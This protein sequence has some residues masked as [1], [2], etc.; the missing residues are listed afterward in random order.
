MKCLNESLLANML[1]YIKTYQIR[2]GK[3]PSYRNI[4]KQF[5]LSS[6]SMVNRYVE[7]LYSRGSL[8]K[9]ICGN[10]DISNNLNAGPTITAPMVGT[11]TCGQP[12][13][14]QENIE[15]NFLLPT[16]IFGH[17]ECFILHAKG[18]SMIDKG[19]R[20]GDLL[21]V[22]K[23]ETAENGQIVVALLDDEATVKTFY[24]KNDHVVL[25]PENEK[26][27]DIITNNVKILGIVEQ[28]I[29]KF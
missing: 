18:D 26:Y 15:G 20:N 7:A 10:I 13:Y 16:A 9:S 23:T 1:E 21:V 2:E 6:L 28:Y 25:H 4:Q 22:K 14:A 8:K 12:I 17:G 27:D 29:H 19:I 24:R 3:S 11:V 5:K